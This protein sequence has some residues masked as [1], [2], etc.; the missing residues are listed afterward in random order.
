MVPGFSGCPCS[1]GPT[2]GFC[3]RKSREPLET[4]S[5]R[6]CEPYADAK[7]SN[8]KCKPLHAKCEAAR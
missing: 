7:A 3:F 5:L 2:P 1:F 6:G 4:R 8:V